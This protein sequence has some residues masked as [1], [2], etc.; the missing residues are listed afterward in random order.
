[1]TAILNPTHLC[2]CGEPVSTRGHLCSECQP[3][4]IRRMRRAVAA[5]V[6][7]VELH[8]P[9]AEAEEAAAYDADR[10]VGEE[11]DEER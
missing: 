6:D 4:P 11:R 8:C 3:A 10:R 2:G 1:M 7:A 5:M 9:S